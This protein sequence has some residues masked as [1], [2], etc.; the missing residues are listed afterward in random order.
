MLQFPW[1]RTTRCYVLTTG[2]KCQMQSWLMKE[3]KK[4]MKLR[5]QCNTRLLISVPHNYPAGLCL[6]VLSFHY[7][8]TCSKNDQLLSS[9]SIHQT[10]SDAV[11]WMDSDLLTRYILHVYSMEGTGLNMCFE[12]NLTSGLIAVGVCRVVTNWKRILFTFV[13]PE[14]R[15][16][17]MDAWTCCCVSHKP[18]L[19]ACANVT[20][21]D[22]LPMA[23]HKRAPFKLGWTTQRDRAC[24]K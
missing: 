11:I 24:R 19:A 8:V 23:V 18:A 14:I 16:L 9:F 20:L 6:S 2:I 5:L 12:S 10:A 22:W 21:H 17:N 1:P 13:K 7:D 3:K 15:C 4:I